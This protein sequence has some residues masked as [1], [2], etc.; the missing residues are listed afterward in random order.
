MVLELE[1]KNPGV[2]HPEN[3]PFRR[4]FKFSGLSSKAGSIWTFAASKVLVSE[5]DDE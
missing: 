2:I 5:G 1:L 4:I 3:T